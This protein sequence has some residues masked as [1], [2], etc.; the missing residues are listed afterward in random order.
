MYRYENIR[1]DGETKL[2]PHL[3]TRIDW[4]KESENGAREC[5][6]KEAGFWG[7]PEDLHL[8]DDEKTNVLDTHFARLMYN[9]LIKCN[10]ISFTSQFKEQMNAHIPKAPH[11]YFIPMPRIPRGF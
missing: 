4:D 7:K 8:T 1:V 5:T 6:L 3:L 11:W 9:K 10:K 2:I